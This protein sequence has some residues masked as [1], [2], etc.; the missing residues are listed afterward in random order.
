MPCNLCPVMRQVKSGSEILPPRYA[1]STN[2]WTTF[3]ASPRSRDG[4]VFLARRVLE[5]TTQEW[6]LF[7]AFGDCRKDGALEAAEK[8]LGL[9]CPVRAQV[10]SRGQRPRKA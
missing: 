10:S 1:P 7:T 3:A 2:A 5:R 9:S 8:R 4:P 6:W